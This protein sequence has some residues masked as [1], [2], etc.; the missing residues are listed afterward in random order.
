[1]TLIHTFFSKEGIIHATDSNLTNTDEFNN[2][3]YAGEVKKLFEI[4]HL[5][6]ALTVAGRYSVNKISMNNWLDD[7][8]VTQSNVANQT[9][10][11]FSHKLKTALEDQMLPEEK[12]GTLIHIAGYVEE[13]GKSH[14]ELWFV[15]NVHKMDLETGEYGDIRPD[16]N[17]SEDFWRRD[18]ADPELNLKMVFEQGGYQYYINGFS[19]GRIVYNA[20]QRNLQEFYKSVWLQKP[21][22]QFR[23]PKTIEEREEYI[24]LNFQFIHTLFLSSDYPAPYIGGTPQLFAIAAPPNSEV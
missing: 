14:P 17:V 9:L 4:P 11:S 8:I 15:R 21:M 22:W 23:S 24:R 5:N 3:S 1:M 20:L 6:A 7:F 18:Y 19:S 16:F 13:N 10:E 12:D 2:D